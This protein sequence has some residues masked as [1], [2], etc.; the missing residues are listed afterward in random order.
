MSSKYLIALYGLT[1]FMV[2]LAVNMISDLP[3][4][5]GNWEQKASLLASFQ[6]PEDNFY[7]PGGAILLTPFLGFKP[8]F[9]VAVFFYFTISSLVYFS[10]CSCLIKNK[11]YLFIALISFTFN[12]YLLWLVNSSQDLVFELF[13]L[14]SGFALTLAKKYIF[15]FFPIYLLCLT[16]PQYWPCF[17]LLPV[18]IW[19]LGLKNRKE[20]KFEKK[21]IIIPFLFLL[22]TLSINQLVFKSPAIAGESGLTAQFGHNKNWY[23]SMPKFDS[24]VFLSTGGNMDVAQVLEGSQKLDF[25]S[26]LEMRAALVSIIENPKSLFL[27]TLQKVDTYFFAVQKNPQLSG[28]FYLAPDQKTIILGAN[29]DSWTLLIGSALYFIY[30]AL[31]LIFTI[32]AITIL[33]IKPSIRENFLKHPVVLFCT[34]YLTG[35]IAAIIFSTE[36]RLKIVSEL[37]LVPL[38]LYVFDSLKINSQ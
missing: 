34:P 30:R 8:H 21:I 7:P 27:N 17:L 16:R 36:T 32:S 10:I 31:L 9:E 20:N 19:F 29:R 18:I 35:S 14:L 37:L 38:V 2:I 15:A 5:V 26:D 11:F 24:D 25:I 23:L 1:N 22:S 4:Y 33:V 13:L 6:N 12:P 3:V 28:E